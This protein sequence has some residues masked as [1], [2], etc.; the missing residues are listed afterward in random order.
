MATFILKCDMSIEE[1]RSRIGDA[2]LLPM[3]RIAIV[4]H[5]GEAPTLC[6]HEYEGHFTAVADVPYY[7]F[8]DADQ[9]GGCPK[10]GDTKC[11]DRGDGVLVC[12]DCGGQF[13]LGNATF[14]NGDKQ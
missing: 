14:L 10:C 5:I 8:A 3:S 1:L 9:F 2:V 4:E 12:Q 11:L 7:T 6:K 13:D